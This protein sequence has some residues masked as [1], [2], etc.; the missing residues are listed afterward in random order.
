MSKPN[1]NGGPGPAG[2]APATGRKRAKSVGPV[3]DLEGH[4]PV[5][6]GAGALLKSLGIGGEEAR[7]EDDA[8]TV[9]EVDRLIRATGLSHEDRFLDVGCGSGRHCLELARRGYKNVAGAERSR[10]LIRNA[11]RT[12]QQ[13]GLPVRFLERDS[14]ELLPRDGR[15]DCAALLG[16]VFANYDGDDALAVIEA[17]KRVLRPGGSLVIDL[18]DGDW[19]RENFQKSGWEWVDGNHMICRERSLSADGNRLICRDVVVNTQKGVVA[20]RFYALVLY[21]PS[22]IRAL[23]EGAGLTALR[24]QVAPED[25]PESQRRRIWVIAESPRARVP[26]PAPLRPLFPEVTV[27]LGD[28]RM[29]DSMKLGDR[30]T[31]EDFEAVDRMKAALATVG[32]YRFAYIDDHSSLLEELVRRRPAFVFNM[33]DNGYKNDAMR[34][35]ELPALLDLL[36]VPYTGAGPTCL[37][38]CYDKSLVRALAV[39]HGVPVPREAY[40][41]MTAPAGEIPSMFP[42]LIKPNRADGSVGITAASVVNSAEEALA[43]IDGLRKMLPGRDA[44]I[45]EYLTGAE[46]SVGLIGNPGL[47]F[48]VLPPLEVDYSGLDPDLPK[49]LSY[50]SK[51]VP[52]SP[53]FTEIKYRPARIDETTR[54]RLAD[55]ARVMF[56]RLDCRD[57]ARVDFRADA[58]GEIKLLEVNPNP[59]WCW[60][61]KMAL[62]AGFAGNGYADLLRMILEAAQ[63]RVQSEGLGRPK[64]LSP[65]PVA[66]EG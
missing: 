26:E 46:Y 19:L 41:D 40:Y 43:Y 66:A 36:E 5:G 13:A 31:P 56:E 39:A 7:P 29:A 45:Q 53:Y 27:I 37:G 28:P 9:A 18:E 3:S 57:Y 63:S 49:I 51:F 64:A 10:H 8:A 15:F 12:A 17:V 21:S 35:L 23:L 33:C 44:L 48:N 14:R 55:Y 1:G 4:L 34:E 20:D 30:Y 38:M 62:M 60:D 16:N 58:D 65:I 54:R 2:G 47:G 11:R 42:A 24:E 61:G 52:G 25:A 32:H 59:A 22:R 6:G 50:E